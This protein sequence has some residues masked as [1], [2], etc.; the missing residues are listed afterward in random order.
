MELPPDQFIALSASMSSPEVYSA[1]TMLT[2]YNARTG[3]EDRPLIGAGEGIRRLG[4]R[5]DH[6]TL[7]SRSRMGDD[8][9]RGAGES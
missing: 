2:A 7:N 5:Q 1:L 4:H 6:H 3:D 9:G 8:R